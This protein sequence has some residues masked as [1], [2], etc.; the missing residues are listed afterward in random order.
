MA[1]IPQPNDAFI[2]IYNL[3]TNEN[4]EISDVLHFLLQN[5]NQIKHVYMVT[6]YYWHNITYCICAIENL[7]ILYHFIRVISQYPFSLCFGTLMV[8]KKNN[9]ISMKTTVH[10]IRK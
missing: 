1:C 8:V 4:G 7:P 5:K 6:L 10:I 2:L 9:G 3:Y